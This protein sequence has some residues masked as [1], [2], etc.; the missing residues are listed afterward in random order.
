MEGQFKVIIVGGGPIGLLAAHTLHRAGI[1]FVLFERRLSIVEDVGAS[2]VLY[3]QTFRVLHQLGIFETLFPLGTEIDHHLSFTKD[4]KVFKESPKFQKI[5]DIHGYGLTVFHRAELLRVM[6]DCLPETSKTKI[7][8][9]KKLENIEAHDDGVIV[10]C[11]DG[12]VFQG[13]MVIGADGVHSTT[14]RLM[15]KIALTDNPSR[16]WDPEQPYKSSFRLLYGAFPASSPP[17]QGYDVQS[18]GKSSMYFSGHRHGWF[19]LYDKLPRQTTESKRYNE[20]EVE[21][22]AGEFADFPL[23]QTFKVKDVWANMSATGLTDLQEGVVKNW[24]LGRIVLVGDSCHKFTTHLGLGLNNGVQ[25]VVVLCNDLRARVREAPDECPGADALVQVFE[26]YETT[27]KSP[28]CS[29]MGDWENSGLE[30]RMH[31]WSS[32]FY[33]LL[34]R[35]LAVWSFGEYL[36]LR[37]MK[38]PSFQRARVLDFIPA[39]DIMKGNSPW[40]YQMEEPEKMR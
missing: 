25:D 37:F 29:L 15:R 14:R 5:R 19:F 17:G 7:L 10:S 36:I 23:T 35:W 33:W 9:G 22:L 4:G 3:P 31:T 40:L 34:S 18:S 21:T 30:T 13:S 6:Y 8:T 27:R 32:T 11:A 26:R 2:I 39:S 1:D 12:C 24:S 16:D 38:S 20:K 28:D